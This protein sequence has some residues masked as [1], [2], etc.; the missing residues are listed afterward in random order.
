[1]ET[2]PII[3]CFSSYRTPV[4]M[5]SSTHDK[6]AVQ[7]RWTP[8]P[9]LTITLVILAVS[10]VVA[11]I[12]EPS[13]LKSDNNNQDTL[14]IIPP[15]VSPEWEETL[16]S[17]SNGVTSEAA[18]SVLADG[19]ITLD[20]ARGVRQEFRSC[21]ENAG[22][23]DITIDLDGRV[24]FDTPYFNDTVNQQVDSCGQTSGFDEVTAW[25]NAV[26]A[27][28]DHLDY[29]KIMA[30][31]LV[32]KGVVNAD[33]SAEQFASDNKD[34][35]FPFTVSQDRGK[36]AVLSCQSNPTGGGT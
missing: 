29:N 30:T 2:K 4:P 10:V 1:M 24:K 18:K 9:I 35:S 11:I 28:P 13:L 25:L 14:P 20:E 17:A 26:R 15:S 19:K 22:A 27:N 23:S 16:K 33:Y 7:K 31:C 6:D 3:A 8:R 12:A 34:F 5:H 21:A 36:D 32:K